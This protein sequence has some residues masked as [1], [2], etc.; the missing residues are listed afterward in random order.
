[1]DLDGKYVTATDGKPGGS[2]AETPGN[3]YLYDWSTGAQVFQYP[4]EIMNWPMNISSKGNAIF[5]ASDTGLGY[6]WK[7]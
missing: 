4:T 7:G 5:A 3:S 1:M 6:Y 2:T